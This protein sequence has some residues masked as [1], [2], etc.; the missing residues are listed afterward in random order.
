MLVRRAPVQVS[1]RPLQVVQKQQFHRIQPG[2]Q[3]TEH[4]LEEPPHH[5]A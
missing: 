3:L 4:E 1:V 5:V 2:M